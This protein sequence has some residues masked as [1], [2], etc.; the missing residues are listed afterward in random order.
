MEKQRPEDFIKDP[1]I[2]E[3]LNIEQPATTNES[4]IET[5]LIQNLQQFLLEL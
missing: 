2:F 1:Y 4:E 3:F 5:A